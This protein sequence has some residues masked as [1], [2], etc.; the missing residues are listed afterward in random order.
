[1]D[2]KHQCQI[3]H[4]RTGQTDDPQAATIEWTTLPGHHGVFL[5]HASQPIRPQ[6]DSI[7]IWVRGRATSIADAAFKADF[8][9]F[10]LQRVRTDAVLPRT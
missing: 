10:R 6:K 3:G 7:S 1:V 8:D 9:D 2:D 4:D 5:P